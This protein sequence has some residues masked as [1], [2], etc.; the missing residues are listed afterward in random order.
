[1]IQQFIFLLLT[2]L[3]GLSFLSLF[4]KNLD[5]IFILI[6]AFP[7]GFC[8]WAMV[9]LSLLILGIPTMPLVVF[10]LDVVLLL[11][12]IVIHM[13]KKNISSKD[14]RLYIVICLIFSI[15]AFVFLGLNYSFV[16]NDSWLLIIGGK[17]INSGGQVPDLLLVSKGILS[18]VYLSSANYFGFDYSYA[19]FPLSMLSLFGLF[20]YGLL[21]FR[22]HGK[23]QIDHKFY[24]CFLA[25]L[26]IVSSFFVIFSMFYI[27]SNVLTAVFTFLSLFSLYQRLETKQRV[28]TVLSVLF[29]VQVALLR[30][31]GGLFF[32]I[33]IIIFIS[34]K[35]ISEREKN[36]YAGIT[37]GI[38]FLWFMR[39]SYSLS[40]FNFHNIDTGYNFQIIGLFLALY[41][42][43]L[44]YLLINRFPFINRMT[45]YLPLIFLIFLSGAWMF[46]LF[47]RGLYV[48]G[49]AL[50]VIK[51]YGDL[52]INLLK[53]GRWGVIWIA[54]PILFIF[55]VL[56]KKVKHESVFT[57]YIISFLLIF[58]SIN[59]F[60]YGW[61]RGWGDSGNRML[62]H[63]VFILAFYVFL[64]L[65]SF[66]FSKREN[67]DEN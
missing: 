18:Y 29:L 14:L 57:I 25:S 59:I 27:I 16:S 45:T 49:A 7:S 35:E 30:L 56:I 44:I 54:L 32:L 28:W 65:A 55:A 67:L 41:L 33:P 62:L 10:S 22:N 15:F 52:F 36:A 24:F 19:L 38:V 61:R 12:F 51:R 37:I 42:M 53:D 48:K 63:V 6:L 66:I 64:K 40:N 17:A 11:V 1:M 46:M 50:M 4:K 20:F 39:L 26:F 9:I 3:L 31:E 47:T 8:L 60:R 13:I 43:F 58:N 34:R 21:S 2:F 5:K 23:V